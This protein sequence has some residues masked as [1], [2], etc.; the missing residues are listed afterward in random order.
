[1]LIADTISP[2]DIAAIGVV[3]DAWLRAINSDDVEALAD[4][5][6]D[7]LI[8]LPPNEPPLV[9]REANRQWHRTRIAQ[10]KTRLTMTTTELAGG[11][12]WAFEQIAFTIELTPRAGGAPIVDGGN[13][14]WQW[15][16]QTD[17]SWKVARAIWNSDTPLAGSGAAADV[18][19]IKEGADRYAAAVNSGDVDALMAACT[20]DIVVMPPDGPIVSGAAAVRHWFQTQF[21]EVFDSRRS[22]AFTELEVRIDR[23]VAFGPF[24]LT[25]T[26]K[27]EAHPF[28][29]WE[30]T[31]MS[32]IGKPMA[33]G[34]SRG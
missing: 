17:G 2:S 9:G 25:L 28:T 21:V 7:D 19:A 23:A 6:T 5:A 20:E 16:R 13:C 12:V 29:T 34:S 31:S 3:R 27:L 24:Q 10:F 11:G 22:F 8:A 14:L 18:N 33:R 15:Q 30:S 26:P 32:I 1:M 4:A